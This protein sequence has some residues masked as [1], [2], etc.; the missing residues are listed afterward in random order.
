MHKSD[1]FFKRV[2]SIVRQIPRGKVCTYGAIAEVLGARSSARM[3]GYALNAAV[4]MHD[5]PAH[6]VV[7]R[8]GALTGRKHF[9]GDS[10]REMLL[11]ESVQFLDEYTV[12]IKKH[13]WHPECE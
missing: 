8:T 6:R 9:P 2:Y 10:M 5:V 13:F 7:N 11:Q 12:D 1:D 4:S 3:V